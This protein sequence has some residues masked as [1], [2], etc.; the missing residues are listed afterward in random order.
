MC[1][2]A[3]IVV[4]VAWDHITATIA[5]DAI[6]ALDALAAFRGR[7][8]DAIAREVGRERLWNFSV[9]QRVHLS[10]LFYFYFKITVDG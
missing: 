9:L 6:V 10:K 5:M 3:H 2:K 8:A 4:T 1:S 7:P